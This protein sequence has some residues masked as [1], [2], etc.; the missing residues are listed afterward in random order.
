MV[1]EF[2]GHLEIKATDI[3][4]KKRGLQDTGPV[5]RVVDSE[6]IRYMDPYIPM[7]NGVLTKAVPLSTVVGSGLIQQ[8][9]PYSRYQYYGKLMVDPI[10]GKGA[11][12]DEEGRMWSR[13]G[14]KKVLTG[15]DLNYNKDKHPMA[16]PLW[17]ERMKA[18]HKDD[19]LDAARKTAGAK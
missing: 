13:P 19:I 7:L 6:T 1:M 5:Q 14:V 8:D 15:T 10:T 16:G 3:I 9:T 17:F 18:D 2:N 4:K 12:C 11:F